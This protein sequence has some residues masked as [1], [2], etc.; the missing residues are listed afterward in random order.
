MV[1]YLC[2]TSLNSMGE[3]KRWIRGFQSL[4]PASHN[5]LKAFM[6]AL[7]KKKRKK[8]S[9]A[10]EAIEWRSEQP[11]SQRPIG[12]L[13]IVSLG[14]KQMNSLLNSSLICICGKV[15]GEVIEVWH[16][17][18]KQRVMAPESSPR[19]GAVHIPRTPWM[20]RRPGPWR[21]T[22]LYGQKLILLIFLPAFPKEIYSLSQGWHAMGKRK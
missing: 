18:P 19:L 17:S 16:E 22:P 13:I 9:L 8:K 5:D 14:E 4:P 7:T 12:Y 11:D 1:T 2:L 20:K 15:L 3:R 21:K 10:P 6:F